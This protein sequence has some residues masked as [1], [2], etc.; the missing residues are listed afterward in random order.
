MK[1]QRG[2]KSCSSLVFNLGARRVRVVNATLW[3]LYVPG[4]I[5]DAHFWRGCVGPRAV[6]DGYGEDKSLPPPNPG[7]NPGQFISYFVAVPNK[8]SR[9]KNLDLYLYFY[10]SFLS[11]QTKPRPMCAEMPAHIPT[12]CPSFLS[13]FIE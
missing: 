10:P 2:V 5:Q 7:S 12:N 13:R 6:L 9:P 4:K 8:L 3:S 11:L 1:T